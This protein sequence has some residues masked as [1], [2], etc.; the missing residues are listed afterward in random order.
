MDPTSSDEGSIW[1]Y[2]NTKSPDMN[3][4]LERFDRTIR[5]FFVD[6]REHVLFTDMELFD[7]KLA[8]W[9]VF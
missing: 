3:A 6:Y 4:H 2:T 7:R 8:Q 9:L 5:E 1:R